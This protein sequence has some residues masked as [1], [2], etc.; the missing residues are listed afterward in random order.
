MAWGAKNGLRNKLDGLD[1]DLRIRVRRCWDY[2]ESLGLI[3]V[4]ILTARAPLLFS[5]I[6]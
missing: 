1:K 4:C 2:W 6:L 3:D 5:D